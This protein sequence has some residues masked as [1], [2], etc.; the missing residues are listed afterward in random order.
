MANDITVTKNT[1]SGNEKWDVT[2][3]VDASG[4]KTKTLNT[5][6]TLLDRNI[7][8]SVT[9]PTAI[10]A[11]SGATVYCS[12]AGWV[13]AG[14]A[15]NGIGTVSAGAI[16]NN[17]TLPSGSTSS[18]SLNYQ[19]YI[20]IGA[21]YYPS[22]LY[23]YNGVGAISGSIGGSASAGSATAVLTNTNSINTIAD[24]SGKTAGTDYWT[25]KATATTSAG[26]YTPKYTV[27]TAGYLG[28]TVTGTAQTV[29]VTADS[30]GTSIY[31]PKATYSTSAGVTTITTAGYLPANTKVTNITTQTPTTSY[32]NSGLSTYFSAGSSSDYNVSITP[33]YSNSAGYVAAHT[34]TN[35][36]GIGYWKIKTTS[37]TQGTST[38]ASGATSATRGTATWETGWIT[39]GSIDA[40][41]FANTATSGV[42]YLDISN[43]TDSPMLISGDYLYINKGYTDNLKISL[44][45][46][47]PDWAS[48]TNVAGASQMLSGYKAYDKDGNVLTG[49]I[50]SKAATTYNTS[51]SNQTIEAGQ[52]LSGAQTIRA[53]TTSNISAANIKHGVNV[54]V[55]DS[56]SAGRI[57]NVTGTFTSASTVSS[58]QTAAAA[59]Q[60]LSGYSAWVDGVE[61]KG[62]VATGTGITFNGKTATA[63]AGYYA[64]AATAD[65]TEAAVTVTASKTAT[66]PTIAKTATTAS[67]AT[68]V[69]NG[70]ATTTAPTSGYFVSAQATAPITTLDI[71]KTVNTAGYIGSNTQ[72]T[73]SA[74]TTAKTGSVYYIPIASGSCTVAGGVLSTS[75]FS[76]ADLALTLSG[77]TANTTMT[78]N[79]TVGAQDT[80]NYPYYI[81]I[82]GSTPAVNGTTSASVTAITD[83]HTAGYI[84]AKTA[85][86]FRNAQSA[87]PSVSVNATSNNTYVNIKAA[88][89][90]T[91]ISGT[92]TKQP[93]ITRSAFT[94]SGVTD[95]ASG[96]A[97]TTA[98]TSGVYVKVSSAANTGTLTSTTAT[99]AGYT[100]ANNS[101]ATKTATVGAS[102]SAATY[103][104][105]TTANP[106]FDGGAISGSVTGITGS[107]VTLSDTDNGISVTGAASAGRAAVLYNGAVNGWVS[108]A[109]NATA[110]GATSS[111]TT[112]TGKTRYITE[113][114]V[115][116]TTSFT[117]TTATG[118]SSTGENNYITTVTNN[119]YRTMNLIN[120]GWLN[121]DHTM[122]SGKDT[123]DA[124]LA[125]GTTKSGAQIVV[126]GSGK[127]KINTVTPNVSGDNMGPYYGATYVKP[128][129]EGTAAAATVTG[130]GTATSPTIAKSGT[131]ISGATTSGN[132]GSGTITT[133]APS[134]GFYVATVATA[135][136]TTLTMTK[137]VNTA[138]YLG[139]NTQ[140]TA[141]AA[142]TAKTGSVY[143]VP[144]TSGVYSAAAAN[145]TAGTI[146]PSVGLDAAATS[147]YGFTTTKPSG[148][149]GTN[150]ITLDPGG[151]VTTKWKSTATASVTTAGYI[152]T[153]STTA[154]VEGSPTIAAGTNYYVPIRTISFSGGDLS[155]TFVDSDNKVITTATTDSY[156]NGLS[157]TTSRAAVTYTNSAG[158]IA[159]HSNT[160]AS[161]AP[162][163]QVNYLK[164]VKIA[165]PSSGTAKFDITVPNGSTTD[166]ITFQFQVDASGNVFVMGPD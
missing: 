153:G 73:A 35:N 130:S 102:A 152:P 144:V 137:T 70:N 13:P 60:I 133:A 8:V 86:N 99:T 127:W 46:L 30:T 12:G 106:A 74:S 41:T 109:D 53:V 9:T 136:A 17:T 16:T 89:G 131:A 59:G 54:K 81:K 120:K 126:S 33:R 68:N 79:M 14:S 69:A 51:T 124:Y 23:Y 164:G 150:F 29:S 26:S 85:T 107:N 80:T 141:S 138:G 52:Y 21:G 56:A 101:Y 4:T 105:I 22:D 112:L 10:F 125:D 135:P 15:S 83:A 93:S 48:G 117:L 87:S 1:T 61:V 32:A 116:N 97:I 38:I 151:T 7:K 47:V 108:K 40:A 34:N 27:T 162:T 161:S 63:A 90:T 147:T 57:K 25:I 49:E 114:I 91:T 92:T 119:G 37:I 42:T 121:I 88:T 142:T 163:N 31:I 44:A 28:S 50:P 20:K 24:I 96:A 134:S 113:I 65:M 18:G 55:G 166:F 157:I 39:A 67:G 71:T 72:I 6:G 111:N 128:M 77:D 146:T 19:K 122:T 154:T 82:S 36:G 64:T 165:A 145:T 156:N 149:T 84:P 155:T 3:I 78:E 58:G 158:V 5:A 118:T 76:K 123:I 100:P 110:L 62:S 11:I 98:P 139:T 94:I 66:A 43:T 115:P 45:K 103:V 2:Y 75:G 129:S 160:T 159:A 140:I 104:P 143:Y 148:T 132:I 95:A